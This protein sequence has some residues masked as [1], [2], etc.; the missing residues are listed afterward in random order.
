M[1]SIKPG[2]GPSGM[3]FIGSIVFVVFGILWTIAAFSMSQPMNN[4]SRFGFEEQPV[5]IAFSIA[6][7][8]GLLIVALGIAGAVY[9]YKNYKNKERY[10]IVDIV[11]S[12][13]EGDP[14][15][16]KA[17]GL[18]DQATS[19][20]PAGN[21]CTDCGHRLDADDAFCPGCGKQLKKNNETNV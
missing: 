14:L 12:S 1:K 7:L 8:F 15:N 20:N 19:R 6:P 10:S 2:R 9:D 13:E 11:D 18:A 17:A 4:F 16:E 3:G 21:F 5:N